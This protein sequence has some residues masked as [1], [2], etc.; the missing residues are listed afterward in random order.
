[1]N[2]DIKF[3]QNFFFLLLSQRAKKKLKRKKTFSPFLSNL[4]NFLGQPHCELSWLS[5]GEAPVLLK[6]VTSLHRLRL[7]FCLDI[8]SYQLS[9]SYQWGKNEH[10]KSSIEATIKRVESQNYSFLYKSELVK[11]NIYSYFLLFKA[12]CFKFRSLKKT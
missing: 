10:N 4:T 6:K 2:S 11:N 1:M 5:E 12:T 9:Y 7:F 8:L 3:L